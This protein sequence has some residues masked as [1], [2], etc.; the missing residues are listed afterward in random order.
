MS[1]FTAKIS[2]FSLVPW[3]KIIAKIIR[4][5]IQNCKDCNLKENTIWPVLPMLFEVE[6]PTGCQKKNAHP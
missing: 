2:I 6:T 4:V 5:F 3:Q 1:K